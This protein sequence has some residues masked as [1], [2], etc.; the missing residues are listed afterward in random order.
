MGAFLQVTLV[1]LLRR[2]LCS[3]FP[4]GETTALAREKGATSISSKAL[5]DL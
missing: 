3:I 1:P 5:G 4:Q 2:G